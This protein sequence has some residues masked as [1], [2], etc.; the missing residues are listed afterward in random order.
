M[1]RSRDE[2]CSILSEVK[3]NYDDGLFLLAEY[4]NLRASTMKKLKAL[5]TKKP[6]A[7]KVVPP[8]LLLVLKH[9]PPSSAPTISSTASHGVPKKAN[10]SKLDTQAYSLLNV[11]FTH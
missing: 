4:N 1:P 7:S 11:G 8:S 9:A 3:S 2:L 5:L 10:T 6:V